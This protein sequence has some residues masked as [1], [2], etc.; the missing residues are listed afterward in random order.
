[1]F[2]SHCRL[3]SNQQPTRQ[4]VQYILSFLSFLFPIYSFSFFFFFRSFCVLSLLL[5]LLL[6]YRF[7][8]LHSA[9][10]QFTHSLKQTLFT[11]EPPHI[12]DPTRRGVVSINER[13]GVNECWINQRKW[14][15]NALLGSGVNH[16]RFSIQ[17][18][19]DW[20]HRWKTPFCFLKYPSPFIAVFFISL[21]FFLHC[22]L[23]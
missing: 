11:T 5:L 20:M 18:I 15:V 9:I 21:S 6:L 16:T 14:S 22:Y 23:N 4:S 8:L 7:F 13:S 2:E 1:M 19:M 17:Q 10:E 3:F 12:N